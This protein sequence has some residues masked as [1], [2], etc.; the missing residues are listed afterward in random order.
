MIQVK[1]TARLSNGTYVSHTLDAGQ[2][3]NNSL[4]PNLPTCPVDITPQKSSN[5]DN[6]ASVALEAGGVTNQSQNLIGTEHAQAALIDGNA[7]QAYTE[8]ETL[9]PTP[10]NSEIDECLVHPHSLD[11]GKTLGDSFVDTPVLQMGSTQMGGRAHV[12]QEGVNAEG[13][14]SIGD[15]AGEGVDDFEGM[16]C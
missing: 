12:D 8:A 2:D 14:Y 3:Q 4:P 16:Q 6:D 15:S 5:A 11:L 7:S 10:M 13:A 1:Q 9:Q